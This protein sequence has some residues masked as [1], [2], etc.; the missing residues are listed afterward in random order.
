MYLST[1]VDK[2]GVKMS[3]KEN[4]ERE[5]IGLGSAIAEDYDEMTTKELDVQSDMCIRN[6]NAHYAGMTEEQAKMVFQQECICVNCYC[7]LMCKV[8][9]GI[10][11]GLVVITRCLGFL[12]IEK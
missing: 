9:A 8:A 11:Q 5:V 12:P 7:N 2:T 4:I 10:D 1:R 3:N 6:D